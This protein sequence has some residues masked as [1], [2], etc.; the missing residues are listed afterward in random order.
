[1]ED[2]PQPD[3]YTGRFVAQTGQVVDRDDKQM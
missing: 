1:M 3:Q 2:A